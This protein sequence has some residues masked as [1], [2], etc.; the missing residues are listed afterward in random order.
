MN[1]VQFH[2]CLVPECG[3]IEALL[4]VRAWGGLGIHP[5]TLAVRYPTLILIGRQIPYVTV[6]H[7]R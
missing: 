5:E 4:I 1:I 7:N 3:Q 6:T 2:D